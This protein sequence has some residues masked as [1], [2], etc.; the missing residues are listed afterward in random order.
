VREQ[1]IFEMYD[2]LFSSE[3][4]E[5][6]CNECRSEN[7]ELSRPVSVWQIGSQFDTSIH[8]LLFVGKNARGAPGDIRTGKV[9]LDSTDRGEDL[10]YNESWAYW[11]YTKEISE[12]VEGESPWEKIAFTNMVKC[13]NSNTTDTTS[14]EMKM[15][16]ILENKILIKEILHINPDVIVFYTSTDYDDYIEKMFSDIFILHGEDVDRLIGKKLIPWWEFDVQL[17]DHPVRCLRTGHPER[18]KKVDFV[19]A[20]SEFVVGNRLV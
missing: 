3:S 7:T 10:F 16:C 13:N 18:K 20:V 11:S 6:I 4:G 17:N 19:N 8:K 12:R 9:V 5:R 2:D 1:E 14:N 15:H